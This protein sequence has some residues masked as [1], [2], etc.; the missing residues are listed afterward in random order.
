[1]NHIFHIVLTDR[2]VMKEK[3]GRILNKMIRPCLR[4]Y[5]NS[6]L[7]PGEAIYSAKENVERVATDL[8][9]VLMGR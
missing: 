3:L 8:K 4:Y 7:R 6:V 9:G 5:F 1:M 2:R